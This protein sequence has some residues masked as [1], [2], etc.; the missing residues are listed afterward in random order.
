M[1]TQVICLLFLALL[2]PGALQTASARDLLVPSRYDQ[3]YEALEVAIADSSDVVVVQVKDTPPYKYEPF[4]MISGIPVRADIGHEPVVDGADTAAVT[5]EWPATA[6]SAT[7]LRG[8]IIQGGTT[9]GVRIRDQGVIEVCTIERTSASS[10]HIGL[11]SQGSTTIDSCSV[12]VTG[13][14][15]N[16]HGIYHTDGTPAIT[17][18]SVY[19]EDGYGIRANCPSATTGGTV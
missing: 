15:T 5:V 4:T 14:Y 7:S 11:W 1:R 16:Y 17:S 8:L 6:S 19:V 2:F 3:I 12:S 13:S 9:A 10:G 18:T